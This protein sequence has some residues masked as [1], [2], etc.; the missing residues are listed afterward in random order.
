MLN[1]TYLGSYMEF[2]KIKIIIIFSITRMV[3]KA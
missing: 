3:G 2:E 1:T